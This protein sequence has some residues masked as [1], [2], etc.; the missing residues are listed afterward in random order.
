MFLQAKAKE[1]ERTEDEGEE[2]EEENEEED[3]HLWVC[4]ESVVD[5]CHAY[6]TDSTDST[7][8]DLHT[9]YGSQILVLSS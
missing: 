2:E 6:S 1:R 9:H 3:V 5:L 8:S 7:R 4:L